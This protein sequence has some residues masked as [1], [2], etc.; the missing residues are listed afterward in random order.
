MWRKLVTFMRFDGPAPV[1]RPLFPRRRPKPA[2][3]P[4]VETG[5]APNPGNLRLFSF[6]P[7]GLKPGAPLVVLL[8]GCG[9]TAAGYDAGTG[10][11]ELAAAHGFA[12]IAAEQKAV[13]N[14]N[15]CFNWFN[16]EDI[17]RDSGEAASIAA[18]IET[19]IAAHKLDAGRVFITGLSA[20]GAMTDAMLALYPEMFAGGA[21][22]AGLPFG[23]AQNVRDALEAMRLPPLRT[24]RQ[25]GDAV[26][27][28]APAA[29]RWPRVSIWHGDLDTT[30][31]ILNAQALAAQWA[32]LH[33]L[34]LTGARQELLE[35]GALRLWWD[36]QLEVVTVPALGHGAPIDARDV[37]QS[38]PYIIDMGLS[39]SRHIAR[40]WGL[41]EMAAVRP[42]APALPKVERLL[43]P[44]ALDRQA[45]GVIQ[46]ALRAAGLLK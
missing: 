45:E 5:F 19:T 30:V 26:R 35:V 11:S 32:D 13:N 14:P 37:G 21:I 29:T 9:Q 43:A 40:F 36:D 27:A 38:G 25:W 6:I 20:G 15:T 31:N 1:G 16:P 4:L 12:V 8:H 42:A 2:A 17:T 33:G 34:A 10:W 3:S 44:Q 18:M 28:A 22:V 7:R 46:R 24:P 39:S 23:A 41:L